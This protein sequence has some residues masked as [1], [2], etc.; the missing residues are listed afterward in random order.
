MF[1][2][3]ENIF[4]GEISIPQLAVSRVLGS[5][6]TYGSAKAIQTSGENNLEVFVDEKTT[7]YLRLMFGDKLTDL[8]AQSW[9][10]YTSDDNMADTLLV[11]VNEATDRLQWIDVEFNGFDITFS[12]AKLNAE[13]EV[14]SDSRFGFSRIVEWKVGAIKVKLRVRTDGS[15]SIHVS[16]GAI[17]EPLTIYETHKVEQP[18]L[19]LRDIINT[20]LPY[21]GFQPMSPIANYVW[22]HLNKDASNRTTSMGEADLNFSMSTA[23]SEADKYLKSVGMRNKLIRAWNG[24]V[25]LNKDVVT[26][27]RQRASDLSSYGIP[28]GNHKNML[29]SINTFNL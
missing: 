6:P 14:T 19:I 12:N 23:A 16:E 9:F 8:L 18:E 20:L 25:Y 1:I 22:F 28:Y 29:R 15:V 11:V 4:T 13:A 24:M 26:F 2:I 27:I 7:E 17:A 21:K 5:L 3:N 10:D